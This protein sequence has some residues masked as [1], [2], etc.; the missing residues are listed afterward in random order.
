MHDQSTS[1]EDKKTEDDC[2][3]YRPSPD[4]ERGKSLK[5]KAGGGKVS[6][7]QATAIVERRLIVCESTQV[8]DLVEQFNATSKCST[9]NCSG[10]YISFYCLEC[11]LCLVVFDTCPYFHTCQTM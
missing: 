5:V 6:S 8:M 11:L 4:E 2:S 10:G 7:G 9:N 1:S 3:D